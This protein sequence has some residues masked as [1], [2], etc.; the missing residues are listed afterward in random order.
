MMHEAKEGLLPRAILLAQ[1]HGTFPVRIVV[2]AQKSRW[3]SC[4]RRGTVSLNWRLWLCPEFVTDYVILHELAHLS[5]MNHS[6]RFWTKV[7]DLCPD[8]E[9]AEAWLK[10]WGQQVIHL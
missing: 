6:K 7:S 5:E 3:G 9:R 2:R 10:T 1:E 4:S 8:F